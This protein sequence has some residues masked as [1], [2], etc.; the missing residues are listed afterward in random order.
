M[1][2]NSNILQTNFKKA[3]FEIWTTITARRKHSQYAIQY[4]C[5]KEHSKWESRRPRTKAD[6]CQVGF[7]KMKRISSKEKIHSKRNNHLGDEEAHRTEDN[8]WS[9]YIWQRMNT[10]ICKD[11]KKWRFEKITLYK[12]GLPSEHR[13]HKREMIP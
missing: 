8:L 10:R 3:E 5:R 2:L 12:T 11:L 4:H 13:I 6:K 7:H 1:T 9:L